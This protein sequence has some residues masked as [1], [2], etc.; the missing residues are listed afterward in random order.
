M[1]ILETSR[2]PPHRATSEEGFE[3]QG[4]KQQQRA[5][6]LKQTKPGNGRWVAREPGV[7]AVGREG[8]RDRLL[9]AALGFSS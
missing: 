7:A 4:T 9:L 3:G 2:S 5:L 8:E 6:D 1:G